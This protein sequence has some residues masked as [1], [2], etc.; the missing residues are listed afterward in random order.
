M[1]IIHH[2]DKEKAIESI[3]FIAERDKDLY[4]IMKLFY[5]ADKLH[6]QRYGRLIAGDIYFA[7]KSGPVPSESYDLLKKVKGYQGKK[8]GITDLGF[9]LNYYTV[10]PQRDFDPDLLSESE[11]ECL[12]DTMN[13]YGH[14]SSADLKKASH[15]EA[16]EKAWENRINRNSVPISLKSIAEFLPEKDLIL[17]HLGFSLNG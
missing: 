3:L 11:M 15:D 6:L 1:G 12:T 9:L 5:L 17:G 16:Y 2:F 8:H 7:M 13:E 14:L 10:K 4:R